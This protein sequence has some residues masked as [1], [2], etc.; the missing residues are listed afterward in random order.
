MK[1]LRLSTGALIGP[2]G[3]GAEMLSEEEHMTLRICLQVMRTASRDVNGFLTMERRL[4]DLVVRMARQ[5]D[6]LGQDRV[7]EEIASHLVQTDQAD[8]VAGYIHDGSEV[9]AIESE[10]DVDAV[11]SFADALKKG[12]WLVKF[13][14]SQCRGVK[15]RKG[16]PTP[17]EVMQSLAGSM[18]QFQ[19]EV[20]ASRELV[21]R[22]PDLFDPAE[23]TLIEVPDSPRESS[24]S[25]GR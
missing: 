6:R 12:G 17:L 14:T 5:G 7:A 23:S 19:S 9:H 20:E 11:V 13:L 3:R 10:G 16:Y 18:D 22:H 4:L 2:A 15:E 8:H 25:A 21:N 24:R 1:E